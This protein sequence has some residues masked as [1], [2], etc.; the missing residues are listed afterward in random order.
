M[1]E[2][3]FDKTSS[4][5]A[6]EDVLAMARQMSPALGVLVV[7]YFLGT[8]AWLAASVVISTWLGAYTIRML[9]FMGLAFAAAPFT[10]SLYRFVASGDARWQTLGQFDDAT[11]RFACYASLMTALYFVPPIG[12]EIVVLSGGAA[13]ADLSWFILCGVVWWLVI[14]A[15]TLLPMAALDPQHASLSRAFAQSRG[16]TVGF[17]FATTVPAAPAFI[18]LIVLTMLIA[19]GAM[20]ALLFYPLVVVVLLAIQL[21]PLAVSTRLYLDERRR[22]SETA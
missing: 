16:Q 13:Y 22:E 5:Q 10:R 15:T 20:H 9:L 12:R 19:R 3:T 14:R 6:R 2:G 11:R 18:A 1:H 17:F 8:M 4:A 21:L 7:V